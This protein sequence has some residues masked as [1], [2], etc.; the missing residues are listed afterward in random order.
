MNAKLLTSTLSYLVLVMSAVGTPGCAAETEPAAPEATESTTEAQEQGPGSPSN[1]CSITPGEPV[2]WCQCTG[3]F[4]CAAMRPLCP[5]PPV[6]NYGDKGPF[7]CSCVGYD[8]GPTPAPGP[9]P[10]KPPVSGSLAP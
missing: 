1:P 7:R 5:E 2:N 6:C 4:A 10:I 8:V 9:T 3:V